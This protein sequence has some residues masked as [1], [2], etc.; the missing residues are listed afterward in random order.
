[1][2]SIIHSRCGRWAF[3]EINSACTIREELGLSFHVHA[4]FHALTGQFLQEVQA[5]AAKWLIAA[6]G[7]MPNLEDIPRRRSAPPD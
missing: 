5:K 4:S 6:G 1:M 2:P 3:A 7:T